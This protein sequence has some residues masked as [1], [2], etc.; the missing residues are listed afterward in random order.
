[1]QCIQI[2]RSGTNLQGH[3]NTPTL[4]SQ[5]WTNWYHCQKWFFFSIFLLEYINYII[6]EIS[7]WEINVLKLISIFLWVFLNVRNIL[8]FKSFYYFIS[9][10]CGISIHAYNVFWSCLPLLLFFLISFPPAMFF[11]HLLS[12]LAISSLIITYGNNLT[13]NAFYLKIFKN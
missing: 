2:P 12:I 1:M 7:L 13:Y 8:N 10:Y 5:F 11:W 9:I 3:L 6:W 4:H